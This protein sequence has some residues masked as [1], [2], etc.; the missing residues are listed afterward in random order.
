M[1]I[2]EPYLILIYSIN[3]I[4]QYKELIKNRKEMKTQEE[5][6]EMIIE[7][8][9]PSDSNEYYDE[10]TDTYYNSSGQQLRNPDEYNPDSEGYTPFGDE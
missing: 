10:E 2:F 6:D 7:Y 8:Y 3:W 5:L 1:Y 4:R 9:L